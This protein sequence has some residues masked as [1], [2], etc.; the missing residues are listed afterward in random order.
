MTIE[1][2]DYLIKGFLLTIFLVFIP[3][4]CITL[5]S[6]ATSF[7]T[8]STESPEPQRFNYET[9]KNYV[10]NGKYERNYNACD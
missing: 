1:E 10:I 3:F 5:I 8:P 6:F 4:A 7:L 2:Q 9:C